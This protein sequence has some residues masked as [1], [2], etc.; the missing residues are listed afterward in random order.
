MSS[1]F[2]NLIQ[3][4]DLA[5]RMEQL[6]LMEQSVRLTQQRATVEAQASTVQARVTVRADGFEAVRQAPVALASAQSA[7][8]E[9]ETSLK[10]DVRTFRRNEAIDAARQALSMLNQK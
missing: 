7:P 3:A 9:V 2:G 5:S 10:K 6:R 4:F 1:I 8:V